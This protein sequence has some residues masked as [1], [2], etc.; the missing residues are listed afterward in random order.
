MTGKS[1]LHAD[2]YLNTRGLILSFVSPGMEKKT[3]AT[4]VW[5]LHLCTPLGNKQFL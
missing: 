4:G 3:S 1:L 2:L 5:P